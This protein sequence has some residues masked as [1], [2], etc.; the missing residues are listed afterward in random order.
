MPF[1]TVDSE[2]VVLGERSLSML[3]KI[4]GEWRRM[5]PKERLSMYQQLGNGP[6]PGDTTST[7]MWRDFMEREGKLDIPDKV[8]INY[9]VGSAEA[10]ASRKSK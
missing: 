3:K 6:R 8:T 1:D 4:R 10:K 5:S 7:R 9:K 2:D